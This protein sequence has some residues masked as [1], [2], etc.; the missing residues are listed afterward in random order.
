MV[1][2]FHYFGPEV[3]QNIMLAEH[4]REVAA[5]L[6]VARKQKEQD[7]VAGNKIQ[8]PAPTPNFLSPHNNLSGYEPIS[9]LIH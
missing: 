1:C 4:V 3:R 5:Y 9:G 2:W 6:M 8:S 7:E